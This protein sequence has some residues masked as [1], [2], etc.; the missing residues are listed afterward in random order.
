ML[1]RLPITRTVPYSFLLAKALEAGLLC[2]GGFPLWLTGAAR[3]YG[4][5]DLYATSWGQF[6]EWHRKFRT[7]GRAHHHTPETTVFELGADQF[8]LVK[9]VEHQSTNEQLLATTDLTASACALICENDDFYVLALYPD[10][11]QSRTCRVLKQ[12][13]WTG[14]RCQRYQERGF[15]IVM[16]DS[17]QAT[18]SPP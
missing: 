17:P 7:W 3:F 14:Y 10:D 5:I 4:D 16:T 2:V 18:I 8:Q 13:D 9:P 12:H 1:T 11:I 15:Q 6:H